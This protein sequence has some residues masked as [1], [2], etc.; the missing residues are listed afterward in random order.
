MSNSV[1][2]ILQKKGATEKEIDVILNKLNKNHTLLPF[3]TL[4]SKQISPE[5]RRM[6]LKRISYLFSNNELVS[7]WKTSKVNIHRFYITNN[8]P[9]FEGKNLLEKELNILLDCGN[10]HGDVRKKLHNMLSS[11]G[12]ESIQSHYGI[13]V[14]EMRYYCQ[15]FSIDLDSYYKVYTPHAAIPSNFSLAENLTMTK[16]NDEQVSLKTTVDIRTGLVVKTES[17]VVP[18]IEDAINMEKKAREI[19]MTP[20][21]IITFL[22]LPYKDRRDR[23]IALSDHYKLE[24][25]EIEK[26]LG[27]PS[28]DYFRKLKSRHMIFDFRGKEKLK[29]ELKKFKNF[30][31]CQTRIKY[32]IEN[33]L[34]KD[35]NLSEGTFADFAYRHFDVVK[36]KGEWVMIDWA[37]FC[38]NISSQAIYV[39]KKNSRVTN[40]TDAE[41]LAFEKDNRKVIPDRDLIRIV[42]TVIKDMHDENQS[43][44]SIF[45]FKTAIE[46]ED[47]EL[48]SNNRI[49]SIIDTLIE[50][51]SFR[52]ELF[53]LKKIHL[54]NPILSG[55][56]SLRWEFVSIKPVNEEPVVKTNNVTVINGVPVL[57]AEERKEIVKESK[58]I[59]VETV[60]EDKVSPVITTKVSE[61]KDFLSSNIISLSFNEG[62]I[63]EVIDFVKLNFK[64]FGSGNATITI[65][66]L[67]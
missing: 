9:I 65:S 42:R 44:I 40:L 31:E 10:K 62:N 54:N 12:R 11:Y 39:Y 14:D 60:K 46:K 63:D 28:S 26:I 64:L 34:L 20:I 23:L 51:K 18:R 29:E 58:P 66:K 6:Y 47:F 41:I 1:V 16:R 32:I 2:K 19:N 25:I 59:V 53:T 55:D 57:K 52:N 8:L 21:S 61:K 45:D 37:K 33:N 24:N 36:K 22:N 4:S 50:R 27:I 3:N 67:D 7:K 49:V 17:E 48:D 15:L 38:K 43:W 35:Y 30:A 56:S 13:T 5:A